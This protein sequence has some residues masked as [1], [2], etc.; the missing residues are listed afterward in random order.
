MPL[1]CRSA[2]GEI[3]AYEMTRDAWT[4]LKETYRG[5]GIRTP[6]CE[7]AAIPKTSSLGTQFFAH[8]R[9]NGCSSAP[10]TK[11][12]LLAKSVI[13]QAAVAA[14][15]DAC[16][17]SRGSTPSG[18]EW[19][20][21]VLATKGNA[22][23]AFEVQWSQ[24]T[25]AET[26]RRQGQYQSSGVRALWLFR[27][28]TF[29]SSE[30]VPGFHLSLNDGVLSVDVP[31]HEQ[32]GDEGRWRGQT[33]AQSVGLPSFID[34][35]LRRRL[36]WAPALG[37]VV[38]ASVFCDVTSCWKCRRSTTAVVSIVLDIGAKI[39]GHK[40]VP[41]TIYAFEGSEEALSALIPSDQR[42]KAGIG[43][44]KRRYSKTVGQ[45]YLSNGC[46]HCDAL[47]GRF[48]DYEYQPEESP[49]IRTELH[50]TSSLVA[51]LAKEASE[52]AWIINRWVLH[53]PQAGGD[54]PMPESQ[55]RPQPA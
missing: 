41:L 1:R 15:W 51:A 50:L 12:H 3:R 14:G 34:G 40:A 17:E 5:L 20:A 35:A 32:A 36:H 30:A 43:V 46:C 18:E 23:V 39:R 31:E 26:R 38:P 2:T 7:S 55:E 25:P 16:T 33:W 28:S 22:K 24:Q 27:Q 37:K 9:R 10:E 45:P 19:I 53:L 13:A 49:R 54:V 52:V 4:S 11:E 6:C 47:L 44:I 8:A 42:K 29:P 21:D 48:F